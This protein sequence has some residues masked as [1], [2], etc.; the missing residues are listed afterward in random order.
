MLVSSLSVTARMMSA[1]SASA[2]MRVEGLPP[3]P[4]TAATSRSSITRLS[5]SLSLSMTTTS[6]NSKDRNFAIW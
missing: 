1:L 3:S 2:S 6:I 4:S 5:L